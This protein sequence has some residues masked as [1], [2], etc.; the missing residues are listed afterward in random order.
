M[1]EDID[2][3]EK[4]RQNQISENKLEPPLTSNEKYGYDMIMKFL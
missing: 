1:I 4:E 3:K 2:Q